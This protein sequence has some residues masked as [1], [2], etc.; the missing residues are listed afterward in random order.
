MTKTLI[1]LIG[2]SRGSEVA[3]ES[4]YTN[5]IRPL[6]AD[7]ALVFGKGEEKNSLYDRASYIKLVDE[8]DDWGD[9]IDEIAKKTNMNS[10]DWRKSLLN[11]FKFASWSTAIIFSFRYFVKELIEENELLDKYDQ[12]II[13]RSDHY[14]AFEHP[15]L[16][17]NHIWVPKGED[18]GGITD[19]H[20][21]ISKSNIM[22]TLEIIP[23]CFKNMDKIKSGDNPETVLKKMYSDIGIFSK[24]KRFDRT[25][26]TVKR[27]TEQNRWGKQKP[28]YIEHLGIYSKYPNEYKMTM[29][30]KN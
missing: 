17:D 16:D 18:Y 24:I 22:D 9:C 27:K 8:Y 3:W 12:F 13:T 11:F 21:V 30:L 6:Y 5:A 26:F 7:L 15:T 19:R 25:F 4:L 1:I 28:L 10:I 23:W 14:Y 20:L 2:N 29:N